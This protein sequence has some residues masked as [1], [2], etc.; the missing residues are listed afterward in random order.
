MAEAEEIDVA[1]M[2]DLTQKK[3]KKPK[4]K[5]D[6]TEAAT[7]DAP[8]NLSGS[9]VTKDEDLP[10]TYS[11]GLLLSRVFD[12]LQQN[13]MGLIE[14]TRYTMKPPQLMKGIILQ[15]SIFVLALIEHLLQLERR[16]LYG[17]IIKKYVK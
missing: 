2:F 1:A 9:A 14:K 6:A 3:K 17:L 15:V 12:F 10:P 7:T 16:K 4:K 8:D 11:Y 13:N 5:S